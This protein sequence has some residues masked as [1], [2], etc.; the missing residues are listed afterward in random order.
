MGRAR[1]RWAG[2]SV[3]GQALP[4]T[5]HT[6]PVAFLSHR[7]GFCELLS[8]EATSC[9]S[10]FFFSW[11]TA[12]LSTC[13][14]LKTVTLPPSGDP[15]SRPP[16]A[17]PEEVGCFSLR[18]ARRPVLSPSCTHLSRWSEHAGPL[19]PP[20]QAPGLTPRS[21]RL[22]E[23]LV[24][25]NLTCKR[26]PLVSMRQPQSPRLLLVGTRASPLPPTPCS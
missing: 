19:C 10:G 6:H 5:P 16:S 8:H 26:A 2:G 23:A 14:Y 20:L 13:F 3:G 7:Q 18:R 11:L 22:R 24:L 9:L 17:S 1:G 4:P 12:P 15:A 25:C 21:R